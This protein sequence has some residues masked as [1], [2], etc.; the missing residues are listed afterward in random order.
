MNK[1][2]KLNDKESGNIKYKYADFD[3]YIK[4][5]KK[6]K[7]N[8]NICMQNCL[9]NVYKSKNAK[10]VLQWL[11]SLKTTI[12]RKNRY[13][14]K[15]SS[16]FIA[17]IKPP[18][19]LHAL[20]IAIILDRLM[21]KQ[22]RDRKQEARTYMKMVDKLMLVSEKFIHQLTE[23]L[24]NIRPI[25]API[26]QDL[27]LSDNSNNILE[28]MEKKEKPYD[29][30]RYN[31]ELSKR[32]DH[33]D[34]HKHKSENPYAEPGLTTPIVEK[35]MQNASHLGTH[36]VIQGLNNF[37][38]GDSKNKLLSGIRKSYRSD[39]EQIIDFLAGNNQ[40][41]KYDV[42]NNVYIDGTQI[43]KSNIIDYVSWLAS[44]RTRNPKMHGL[45]SFLGVLKDLNFPKS[46]LK[47]QDRL[48]ALEIG[49]VSSDLDPNVTNLHPKQ[50]KDDTIPKKKPRKQNKKNRKFLSGE[51]R[52]K[53]NARSAKRNADGM[54]KP[55]TSIYKRRS[56]DFKSFTAWLNNQ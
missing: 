54:H 2:Y 4:F 23:A 38:S 3:N 35:N 48:D 20:N 37:Q 49:S 55:Q 36:D 24:G 53:S 40:R 44:K 16:Q 43:P 30:S 17:Y 46:L 7:N 50:S 51:G 8:Q 21:C 18:R 27:A 12:G 39:A 25:Q 19:L 14:L 32:I 9:N 56:S 47:H 1:R 31:N 34:L 41:I 6:I 15:K 13:R 28:A 26:S 29:N 45:S 22:L 42:N 52:K 10:K 5:A 33:L 11:A